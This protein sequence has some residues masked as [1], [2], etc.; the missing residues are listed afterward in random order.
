M[1]VDVVRSYG[2]KVPTMAEILAEL[3]GAGC[4]DGLVPKAGEKRRYGKTRQ[5]KLLEW[6]PTVRVPVASVPEEVAVPEEVV[7]VPE[8]PL[9]G[10]EW[11]AA[12]APTL[13]FAE[14]RRLHKLYPNSDAHQPSYHSFTYYGI[15]KQL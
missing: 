15:C 4:I 12:N 6:L 14:E 9:V 3:S 1:Y 10:V 11:L 5:T 8:K 7:T 13:D 2:G